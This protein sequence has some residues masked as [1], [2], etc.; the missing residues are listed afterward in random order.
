V[1]VACDPLLF[2]SAPGIF[3]VNAS[4]A[5]TSSKTQIFQALPVA[6]GQLYTLSF[7]YR[8]GNASLTAPSSLLVARIFGYYNKSIPTG[9]NATLVNSANAT[10]NLAITANT[11][12][13]IPT[14]VDT[15][16][17]AFSNYIVRPCI[18]G[19]FRLL[20]IGLCVAS[21]FALSGFEA[22]RGWPASMLHVQRG[23]DTVKS[24]CING[25]NIK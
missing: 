15:A 20:G 3:Y 14:N 10:L 2:Y 9:F 23:A 12:F 21:S 1:A 13:Y 8:V 25:K 5:G 4:G 7:T 24:L 17:L 18:S 16:F 6:G 11:T 22:Q 19:R